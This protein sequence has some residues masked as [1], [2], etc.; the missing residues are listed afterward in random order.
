MMLRCLLLL[1]AQKQVQTIFYA[2]KAFNQ[3]LETLN[4]RADSATHKPKM[5]ELND[6]LQ[7]W[8]K[9]L[10]AEVFNDSGSHAQHLPVLES[11]A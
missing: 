6:F 9:P 11:R 2:F 4:T 5:A 8:C 1:S 10:F 3:Q 7:N